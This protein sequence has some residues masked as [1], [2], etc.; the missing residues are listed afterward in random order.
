[1][2]MIPRTTK[3]RRAVTLT[4]V[5]VIIGIIAVLIALLVPA[6]QRVREAALR[7]QSTNN[8]RQVILATHQF[9]SEHAGGLPS[10]GYVSTTT[11]STKSP[12]KPSLFTSILP[13]VEPTGKGIRNIPTYQSP[14]DPSIDRNVLGLTSYAANAQVFAGNPRLPETFEDGTANTIAF[15]EHY[16][17]CNVGSGGGLLETWFQFFD[18]SDLW[19]LGGSRRATFADGWPTVGGDVYPMTIGGISVG[20]LGVGGGR[21]LTLTFQVMPRVVA[22]NPYKASPAD[23]NPTIPQTPHTGGMLTA[24]GDGSVRILSPGI[25][26][27]TFWGAVT[28]N[29]GE[30][31]GSDW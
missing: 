15:A 7:T 25:A 13:Y 29:G 17:A 19:I 10:A 23:C 14:A 26:P 6:V 28:P 16:G 30:V 12:M 4:E 2:N 20:T 27:T 9:A 31:L 8:L 21:P 1:M 3:V 22:S 18:S 24:L 5:L 11:R